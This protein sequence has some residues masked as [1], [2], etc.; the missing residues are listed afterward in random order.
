MI[1]SGGFE[2]QRT[3]QPPL[4]KIAP[5]ATPTTG[6]LKA[7]PRHR[8]LKVA[9]PLWGDARI[10]NPLNRD[11]SQYRFGNILLWEGLAYYGIFSG[12]EI[13][14]LA[15]SMLYTQPDFTELTIKLNPLAKWSDGRPV[16][17]RD[18]LFSF[19]AQLD[20]DDLQ[21]QPLFQQFVRAF[22]ALDDRTVVLSFKLPAPY[23]SDVGKATI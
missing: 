10:T 16:T 1:F 7:V 19:Q 14:W 8:T 11:G 3:I 21:F 17:A 18:V 23:F 2:G 15:Q 5:R 20:Y 6:P 13:P 22:R 12:K 9:L 4:P